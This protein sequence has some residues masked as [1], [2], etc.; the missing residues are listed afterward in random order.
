MPLA[1]NLRR[2]ENQFDWYP[3]FLKCVSF[4]SMRTLARIDPQVQADVD[5]TLERTAPQVSKMPYGTRTLEGHYS[6]L[7]FPR[8]RAFAFAAR[9]LER[10]TPQVQAQK[11]LTL[12]RSEPHVLID[13]SALIHAAREISIVS[14][15]FSK[16]F[17]LKA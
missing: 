15:G 8:F 11:Y 16:A 10:K 14:P 2:P 7:D 1:S 4:G 3:R 17:H 5:L 6:Y 9:T 13:A 12:E